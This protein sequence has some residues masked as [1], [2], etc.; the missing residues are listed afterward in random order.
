[1]PY[2]PG[3]NDITLPEVLHALSDPI[4]LSII[5]RL[6]TTTEESCGTFYQDLAKSTVSHHFKVLREAG[7]TRTRP[8][9]TYSFLSLRREDLDA[10]FPGLLDAILQSFVA[11]GEVDPQGPA[12]TGDEWRSSQNEDNLS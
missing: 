9:G 7:I 10:R 4:R 6:A 11:S 2:H 12:P 8:E 1:M 3:R 5:R